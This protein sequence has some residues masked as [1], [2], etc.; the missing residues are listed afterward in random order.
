MGK[1]VKTKRL[2]V[3]LVIGILM[4]AAAVLFIAYALNHPEASFPWGNT[5]TYT[6][7]IAYIAVMLT[8]FVLYFS[9]KK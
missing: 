5:V 9:I 6:I 3:F 2:K 8:M 4:L 7:Y 1:T